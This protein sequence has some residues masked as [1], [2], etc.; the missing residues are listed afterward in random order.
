MRLRLVFSAILASGLTL[1][2]CDSDGGGG[3]GGAGGSIDGGNIDVGPGGAGGEGG[4]GGQGGQGGAPVDAAVDAAPRLP[5]CSDGIDNDGDGRADLDDPGCEGPNDEDERNPAQCDDDLDND[6]DGFTDFP[7]DPG[8]GSIFD[9]DEDNPP[10][11]P[12]CADGID[13][14]RDGLVDEQDP[15]CSSAADP[16]EADPDVPPQCFDGIDN[17]LDG[18]IDFPDEPGCGAAGDD[19]EQDPPNPPACANGVDDDGDDYTDYPDDPGC[20]GVG[21]RDE[22]DKEI[23][24]ACFDGQ[25]N[26][27]DG[28]IDYPDDDGCVAASD[29]S[30]RGAC[31][32]VYDPPS[33]QN[34]VS[35]VVDTARGV[36]ETEGSCGGRGSPEVAFQYR[37]ARDVEALEIST[38]GAATQVPTTLYVRRTA[39]LDPTAEVGCQREDVAASPPGHTLVIN[40]PTRGDY[41]I[42]VDGVAGA[43]GPAQV[44]VTERPLA[45]C[46]NRIDDDDDGRIDYPADPGCEYPGDR[47][48]ADGD[49]FPACSNDEDDDGDGLV[50]YPLDVG[51]ISAGANSEVD[52]CGQGV[53][54]E[55]FFF[56]QGFVLGNLADGTNVMQGNCGGQGANE[57]IYFFNNPFNARLTFSTAHPES[58][59]ATTLYVRRDCADRATE[60]GCDTGQDAGAMNGRVVL[61][62]APVGGYWVIVDGRFGVGGPFKLTVEAERLDPGCADGR[63]NDGDGRV[64]GDDPGCASPDDEDE[65]DEAGPPSVCNN[66]EDDDDDGLIDYPYDPGCLT[67]GSGS[68]EDPAVAP[69]CAN[70]QDDDADGFIDFPLDAGCQARGDNNEADPRP[71]PACANRIDDD[72]DGFIDYPFDP[73]CEAAGDG[74]EVDVGDPVCS[75]GVDDD[76]DG[77]ADFPFD[78]GCSSAADPS[79]RDEDVAP[80]CSNGVDDD[81]DDR[82]DFPLDPGCQYAADPDEASPAFAPQCANGRDDDQDGRIDFPDDPGCRFAAD[83]IEENQGDI[84]PRCSDGV[85]NDFDGA[86]DLRDLGCL[87][88]EDDDESDDPMPPPLCGNGVDDDGDMLADWP[89]DPGCQARGDLTEDQ[90]CRPAVMTPLIPRNGTVLGRTQE[91]GADNYYNRCGGRMAPDA[92]YRY[93]VAEQTDLRIS[94][95]NPGTDFPVVLSVRNDCEEP[96]A[97][98]ACAGNFAAPDPTIVLRDAEPGEYYIF[99]DGGGPEQWVGGNAAIAWADPR[100]FRA[101]QNDIRAGCGWSDGGNDAF[102]CFGNPFTLS[103]NGATTAI[104]PTIGQRNSAAGAYAFR[105]VSEFAGVNTWRVKLLPAQEFDERLVTINL[106]GNMGSDGGGQIVQRQGAFQGR[107]VPYTFASDGNDPSALI[108]LVPGDPEQLGNVRHSADRDNVTVVATNIKL[109]ATIYITVSYAAENLHLQGVLGDIQ[110]Q[111]GPGGDDAPRFGNFELSVT[112]E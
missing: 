37:L 96:D 54:F 26:D 65:R 48:E 74:S 2:G 84:P 25:D 4:Q 33:L 31:G 13:N 63:D 29:Y 90:S 22:T 3:A 92:V 110:V 5:A 27:R 58:V 23:A 20:A 62:Q 10:P 11:T 98:L 9:D 14:D 78:P 16:R 55:E 81:G 24:P 72:M 104:D 44:T 7:D 109:P 47:E 105:I 85:D 51:C 112:E 18:I 97:M 94:A 30:E 75:N 88:P 86:I 67:R 50:D 77:I 12:Q 17:D 28:R 89:D 60:L 100:G 43:G 68:E 71:R 8:C 36:F 91:A 49:I 15:G 93:V 79:E 46:L 101:T 99:V 69:A 102:D 41:Y 45:E 56:E 38:V 42:F 57:V 83:T 87:E 40:Q 6:Q 61:E 106:Q 32:N 59:A 107:Q 70:G 64:D 95:A 82:V 111:A 34:G 103:F 73:G 52:V 76:R 39:C 35:L 108:M 21:D 1:V 53:A 19:D 80:V 66:G